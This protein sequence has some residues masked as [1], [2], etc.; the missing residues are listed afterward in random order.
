MVVIL[1]IGFLVLTA[2]VVLALTARYL[3]SRTAFRV[4]AGLAVWFAYVG[5]MGYS[6][7]ARNAAM[8]PP[9]V[10]FIVVPVFVFVVVFAFKVPSA[11]AL[12][13][14][15]W[16]I[17]GT[18]SFRIGVELFLHQLWI[19]GLV[20]KMLTFDG[21]NV[22]IYIGASAALIAWLSTRGKWGMRLALAWNML[23]LLALTNV[24]SR[25]VL[26]AS[27]PF[28]LIHAEVPNRMM[29]TF[30]FLF[31]PGFFV[32]LAVVLHALAIRAISS[33]LSTTISKAVSVDG[34]EPETGGPS[35]KCSTTRGRFDTE[36]LQPV[37]QK[38]RGTS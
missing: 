2:M 18:Q 12:A 34:V 4:L 28:N 14:P 30:P 21:A 29:G 27:G 13:L 23:G 10:A 38:K 3:N 35:V 25:A 22:D 17:M 36:L 11:A 19:D 26:T 6:G 9:G 20:P 15:L 7:V 1:F 37:F 24:V 32:P 5:L 33:Q 8:R 16:I 31:I